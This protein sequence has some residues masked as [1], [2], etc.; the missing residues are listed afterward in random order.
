MGTS[1]QRHDHSLDRT[2]QSR[3]YGASDRSNSGY[4]D[5]GNNEQKGRYRNQEDYDYD[6]DD[7]YH[8][9]EDDGA[10]S[11]TGYL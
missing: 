5:F 3:Y 6:G 4:N 10:N 2:E 7:S 8:D 9:D 1:N 11:M